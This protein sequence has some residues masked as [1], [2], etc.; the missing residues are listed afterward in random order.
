MNHP[1]LKPHWF[2]VPLGMLYYW[3][4]H[5]IYFSLRRTCIRWCKC[6]FSPPYAM[7]KMWNAG[8]MVT[9]FSG[10]SRFVLKSQHTCWRNWSILIL[11]FWSMGSRMVQV[12]DVQLHLQLSPLISIFWRTAPTSLALL[13]FLNPFRCWWPFWEIPMDSQFSAESGVRIWTPQNLMYSSLISLHALLL[14]LLMFCAAD[15]IA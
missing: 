7:M 13:T 4:Y 9:S 8:L 5:S 15:D 3:D 2:V 11:L 6:V 10:S 14:T 12:F 1:S